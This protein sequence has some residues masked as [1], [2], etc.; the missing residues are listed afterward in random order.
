MLEL[1]CQP[2]V[3]GAMA[4]TKVE[5]CENVLGQWSR[6]VNGLGFG[7]K[8]TSAFKSR[9]LSSQCEVEL[10]YRLSE[11]QALVEAQQQQ[12]DTQQEQI[13]HLKALLQQRDQQH[14]QQFEEILCHLRSSQGSLWCLLYVTHLMDPHP[15]LLM[16]TSFVTKI[17]LN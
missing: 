14:Q 17:L 5:I 16:L 2:I 8:P 13:D 1:Q 9:Q 6:Y 10:E 7:P 15:S 3:D 4:M 12:L 11:T